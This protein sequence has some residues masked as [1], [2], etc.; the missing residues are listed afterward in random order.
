MTKLLAPLTM[1]YKGQ[2]KSQSTLQLAMKKEHPSLISFLYLVVLRDEARRLTPLM[3]QA[4][5][6]WL[7]TLQAR[8]DLN[9][10]AFNIK[11]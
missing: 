6:Q 4:A 9:H 11:N 2:F 7:A 5:L 8:I 10:K 1:I 3:Y